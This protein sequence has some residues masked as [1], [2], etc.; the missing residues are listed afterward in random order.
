ML[1]LLLRHG[2]STAAA[3]A[4][5]LHVSVQ[6]MRRHL[7]SLELDGLVEANPTARGPAVPSTGGVSPEL[8]RARFP[9]NSDISPSA[10]SSRWRPAFRRKP[11]GC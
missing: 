11:Y 3:I 4:S 5:T 7:R 6:V 2:E 8:G 9:D 10:C 1:N